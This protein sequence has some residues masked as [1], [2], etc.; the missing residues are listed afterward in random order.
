MNQAEGKHDGDPAPW[1]S[2]AISPEPD[3][4]ERDALIAAVT[5]YLASRPAAENGET[6]LPPPARWRVAG[7]RLAVKGVA[8]SPAMGWG[9]SRGGWNTK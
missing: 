8:K 2:M 9:R 7:R 1:L 6:E 5:A 4:E 3:P